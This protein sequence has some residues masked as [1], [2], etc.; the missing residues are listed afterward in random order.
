MIVAGIDPSLIRTGL[1]LIR[2]AE[3]VETTT[4]TSKPPEKGTETLRSRY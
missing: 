4:V 2:S 1:A 3:R